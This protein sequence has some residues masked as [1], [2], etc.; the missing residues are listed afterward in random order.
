MRS[1]LHVRV[2]KA[3]FWVL[4]G[5]AI[6]QAVQSPVLGV[7]SVQGL[8]WPDMRSHWGSP[9]LSWR[10]GALPLSL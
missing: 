4:Q 3:V 9:L 1:M 5:L 7:G 2:Y 8:A 6:A 10:M